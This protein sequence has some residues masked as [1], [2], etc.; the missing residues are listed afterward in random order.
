MAGR[1]VLTPAAVTGG[2]GWS[3]GLWT[4]DPAAAGSVGLCSNI[5]PG[6]GVST[7][8]GGGTFATDQAGFSSIYWGTNI[9]MVNVGPEIHGNGTG[10]LTVSAFESITLY[11]AGD[12]NKR[13]YR[14][15][16]ATGGTQL[17][18]KSITW[19]WAETT[20]VFIAGLPSVLYIK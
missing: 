8:P 12:G 3:A 20:P 13:E 11:R 2:T 1:I 7:G 17:S 18:D 14:T 5:P 9:L 10:T 19:N 15:A 4:K 16:D 6:G